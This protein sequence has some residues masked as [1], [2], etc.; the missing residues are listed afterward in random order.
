M[1]GCYATALARGAVQAGLG[2]AVPW[3]WDYALLLSGHV[4]VRV[5]CA[6]AEKSNR[7][8][9]QLSSKNSVTRK[10][11]IYVVQQASVCYSS[12]HADLNTLSCPSRY[13]CVL[14]KGPD[15]T[16]KISGCLLAL[17][18][19]KAMLRDIIGQ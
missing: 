15:P 1:S 8:S 9:T 3:F 13:L 7:R 4:Y 12:R 2:Y 18:A 5:H 6:A 17:S 16:S 14:P 11:S 10:G 19:S